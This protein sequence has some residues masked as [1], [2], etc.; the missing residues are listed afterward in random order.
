MA[1]DDERTRRLKSLKSDVEWVHGGS[2]N[3]QVRQLARLVAGRLQ[4]ILD[5]T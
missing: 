2:H 3:E 1:S 5:H 4:M